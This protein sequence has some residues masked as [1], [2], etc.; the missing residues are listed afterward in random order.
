MT[1]NELLNLLRYNQG[2]SLIEVDCLVH[3]NALDGQCYIAIFWLKQLI[4]KSAYPVYWIGSLLLLIVIVFNNSTD[5]RKHN[6]FT[7]KT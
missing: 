6:F 4:K 5:N 1:C 2:Q 3:S 7:M